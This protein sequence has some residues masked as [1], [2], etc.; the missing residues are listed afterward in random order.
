MYSFLTVRRIDK[1]VQRDDEL[2]DSEEEDDRRNID[3]EEGGRSKDRPRLIQINN[4]HSNNIN[5]TANK[6][7]NT[8]NNNSSI[9]T[10]NPNNAAIIPDRTNNTNRNTNENN[11]NTNNTNEEMQDID[12]GMNNYEA[13]DPEDT[14]E[15]DMPTPANNI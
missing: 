2:S 7:N 8:Q 12:T 11:N 15:K 6:N 1:K 5:N 3:V 14:E 10:N 9:S 13:E 4:Q